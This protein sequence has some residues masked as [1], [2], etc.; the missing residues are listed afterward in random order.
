V[1]TAEARELAANNPQSFLHVIRPE[2]DLPDDINPY[3]DAVYAKAKENLDRLLGDGTLI[4]EDEPKMYLYRQVMNH[5][6]QVGIVCCCHIDDYLNNVIKKHEKTRPD[7][8]DDRTRHM[9]TLNANPGPVFLTYRNR[10][11][12]A[13]LIV[14][15]MND[16]PLYHF[17]APDGVTHTIWVVHDP[18]KYVDAFAKVDMAYVADGHH[19]SAAAARAGAEKRGANPNHQGDEEYNWFLTVLFPADEL[20]ILA[21]NRV[22]KDLGD[23]NVEQV[24]ELLQGVGTLTETDE[25]TPDKA[26]VFC[27]YLDGAWYRLEIDP[28]SIDASDPIESLDVQILQKRVLEPIF[29]IGDPRTDKRID[30]VGGSRGTDELK[31]RIDSGRGMVAISMFPTS[32]DQL[33]DVSDADLVMPPKSTWFEPKLRSGLFVHALD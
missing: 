7:K 16:R 28:G 24:K 15:D 26:G 32:I 27:L 29:N 25:P 9:L 5:R 22:I 1:N 33:L 20:T 17:N 21:Y 18:Q 14:G 3:D 31:N 8:E 11:E 13:E 6:P 23:R 10:E 12:I 4:Q 2:I 30:F 19:R